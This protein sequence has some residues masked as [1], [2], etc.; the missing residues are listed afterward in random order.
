MLR[1]RRNGL[2]G[3]APVRHYVPALVLPLALFPACGNRDTGITTIEFWAVG[4]EGEVVQQLIPDFERQNPGIRVRVQ[5]MPWTAAH[6]KILTAF[7][8]DAT[9]DVAQLGNTWVPELVALGA[10]DALDDQVAQSAA[11]DQADFFPGIWDTNII[12]GQLYGVPW[13]VDTRLLFY[14]KDLLERAGYPEPPRTWT[15]WRAA[16]RRLSVPDGSRYGAFLPVNEWQPMVILGLQNG[17]PLLRDDGQ[18]G[19]FQ[20]PAF[21]EAFEFL[22]QLYR[23]RLSPSA[24]DRQLGNLPQEFARGWFAMYISGPWYISEF[25]QRLPAD[26]QDD[27]MTA[28]LPGRGQEYPGVSVAGGA[29]LV[30]FAASERKAAA[31]KLIEYLAA[32][33][34]Q[35]R[36]YELI[37]DLPARVS[38]WEDPILAQNQY[39]RAFRIQLEH[40]RPTPKVPEWERIATEVLEHVEAAALGS[41][42]IDQ[43]LASLDRVVDAVLEKRRWLLARADEQ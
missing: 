21:R 5:Q 18:F 13:Y 15:E 38:A 42:S 11:V 8:G 28:P 9:P 12:D 31:W 33:E 29:S 7:V 27:W 32:P 10:L 6:E 14:R 40:V 1:T 20:E 30:V 43:A 2:D 23:D 36:F 22:I 16:M 19:A 37:G 35:V 39:A 26:L 34:Q 25:R 17:S 41:M 3:R 4:R 24:T